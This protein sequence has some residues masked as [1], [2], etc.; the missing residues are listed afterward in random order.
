MVI[1]EKDKKHLNFCLELAKES[2]AEGN[3]PIGACLTIDNLL[4]GE[5]RNKQ[6]SNE[7]WYNHAENNLIR[8]FATEIKHARKE[9]KS[10]EVYTSLEPCLMCLGAMAHNR[11]TRIIYSCPDPVAGATHIT[12]PTEWYAKKWPT[13]EQGP[14]AEESCK[15][16]IA[17][18]RKIGWKKGIESYLKLYPNLKEK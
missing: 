10:V 7:N 13:I 18:F 16:L 5:D 9:K 15:L 1:S 6:N 2:M 3:V 14:Y 4:L 17:G 8:R 11:I 12:P